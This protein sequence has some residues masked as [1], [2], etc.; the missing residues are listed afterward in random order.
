[1]P[2]RIYLM[3]NGHVTP[4]G[5]AA[6]ESTKKILIIAGP[7]GAGKTTFAREFLVREANCPRFVNADLLAAGLNPFQPEKAEIQAGRLML[8]MIRDIVS[9]GGSFA[10]E[11]T[12]S[13]RIFARMI[14][15]WRAQGYV[16]RLLFFRLTHQE[17]AIE[18][19]AQRVRE[20]GHNVPEDV[21]RR[22]MEKGWRNFQEIYRQIVDE[23]VLYDST[24]TTPMVMER[25]S[26]PRPP[27]EAKM[28]VKDPSL[29]YATEE[30]MKTLSFAEL[31][32]IALKRAAIKA[33]RRAIATQG[34]V[35][36]W[37]NG[38]MYRDTKV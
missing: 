12:L 18:R 24:E 15:V 19:V 22:R 13:A 4:P 29:I 36:T 14:P 27:G 33:R 31:G 6:P 3:Y 1:M 17:K 28:T 20:G 8:V 37:R 5:Q 32:L 7:N 23:W 35:A 9:A 26:N 30:Q 16:V 34:Y 2:S 11:T 10:F 21:I 25:G 38:K